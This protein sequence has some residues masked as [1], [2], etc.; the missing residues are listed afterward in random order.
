MS[1]YRYAESVVLARSPEVLCLV[2]D[3]TR[4]GEWSPVCEACW[5]D[6]GDGPAEST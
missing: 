1:S 5:W 6:N 3:V 4:M 2:C